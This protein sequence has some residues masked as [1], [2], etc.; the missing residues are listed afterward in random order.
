MP[1]PAIV[2]PA[3]TPQTD[4]VREAFNAL[5]GDKTLGAQVRAKVKEIYPDVQTPEDQF[6]PYVAP[7]KA[8]LEAM[9]AERAA[10]KEAAA[11]EKVEREKVAA[12]ANLEASLEAARRKFNLTGDGFD[13]MC[14]RMKATG[15]YTDAEAAAAWVVQQTPLPAAP[16][17][18]LGPQN[19]NLFGSSEKDENFALL[20]A[21]PQGRFL[22][23]EFTAFMK[24]PA[25]YC[26]EAGFAYQ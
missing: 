13:K 1:A 8:E 25:G 21:D 20:H 22:D 15:N 14:E 9:R 16:G 17:P 6:D 4:R 3:E 12:Q 10:E 11:T 26:A 2:A 24:D 7:L 23:A 18:Y 19:I 5:W